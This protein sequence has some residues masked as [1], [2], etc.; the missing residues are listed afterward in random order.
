MRASPARLARSLGHPGAWLAATAGLIYLNQALFTVYVLRV[1]HGDPS[2][3]ARYLPSGWF[4]LARWP[5]LET[6][7]RQ[8]PDPALLAPSVLR[9]QAFLELP[10]VTFAYLTVCRWFGADAYRRAL[11]LAWPASAVWTVTF[12]LVEW[13]L[14]NPYTTDDLVIRAAAG[15]AVPLV[16]ATL[17]AGRL[18]AA[19]PDQPTAAA[20]DQPTAAAP[21]QPTVAAP[22]QPTVAAPDQP[23]NLPGLMVFAVSTAAVGWLVLVVYSTALLYNLGRLGPDLPGAVLALA[24]LA[25]ARAVARHVPSRPPGRG[26]DLIG[27]SFGWFLVLFFVPALP[28]RYGL[29]FGAREISVAAALVVIVAAAVCGAREALA[30]ALANP[31]RQLAVWT[32]QMA[33]TVL[34]GL[35]GASASLLLPADYSETRLLWAAAAFF[36]CAITACACLDRALPTVPVTDNAVSPR[37]R[38]R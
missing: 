30:R 10:F 36:L 15:I 38:R 23:Q 34:A 8:V 26:I 28:V 27:R 24:V 2:F 25:G 13:H 32:A 3:I 19:A 17:L 22:D 35:C 33:L 7:A 4:S 6:L 29:N 16:A 9:V 1:H 18:S 21:D 12:C 11:R 5:A 37:P 14:R 31:P 20:P